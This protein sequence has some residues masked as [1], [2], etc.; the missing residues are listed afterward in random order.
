M[1]RRLLRAFWSL[2]NEWRIVRR[3]ER[4]R[5]RDRGYD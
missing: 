1:M 3:N 5:L 2:F 4:R